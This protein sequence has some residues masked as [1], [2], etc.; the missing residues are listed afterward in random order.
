MRKMLFSKKVPLFAVACLT[1]FVMAG[2]V[3]CSQPEAEELPDEPAEVVDPLRVI[4]KETAS[5][6]KIEAKNDTGKDIIGFSAKLSTDEAYPASLIDAS[7]KIVDEEEVLV[8]FEPLK[9][10]DQEVGA[11]DQEESDRAQDI[12]LRELYNISIVFADNTTAELHDINL[13]DLFSVR[14][15]LSEEGFAYI[16]YENESGKVESTLESEKV[17][18]AAAEEE[19]ARMAAE[20]KAA[21]QAEADARAAEEAAANQKYDYSSG[22]NSGSGASGGGSSG[23]QSQDQCVDDIVLG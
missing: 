15:L 8:C 10:A 20:E 1:I 16:E 18:K 13:D 23:S 9:T 3:G 12:M 22:S 6:I 21:A 17:I 4:G 11:D 14:L 2:F 7:S 19:A 5:A